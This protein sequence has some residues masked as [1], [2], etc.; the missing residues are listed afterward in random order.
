MAGLHDLLSYIQEKSDHILAREPSHALDG[1]L[2]GIFESSIHQT[3]RET[4][5][6][7][8]SRDFADLVVINFI[9]EAVHAG[10]PSDSIHDFVAL[11]SEKAPEDSKDESSVTIMYEEDTSRDD[12]YLDDLIASHSGIVLSHD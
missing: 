5:D 1:P 12:D 4:K 6:G 8:L 3:L 2:F 7:G 11:L 9:I 10:Y